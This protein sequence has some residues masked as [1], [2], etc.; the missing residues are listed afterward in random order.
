[1]PNTQIVAAFEPLSIN[2]IMARMRSTAFGFKQLGS[3]VQD[4]ILQFR[5]SVAFA[6][7]REV[8][9]ESF[10]D[11]GTPRSQDAPRRSKRRPCPSFTAEPS[12]EKAKLSQRAHVPLI[13]HLLDEHL[14]MNVLL[15]Q[16]HYVQ[17]IHY[18]LEAKSQVS[19]GIVLCTS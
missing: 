8:G 2:D 15:R 5:I 7:I 19:I 9:I 14:N 6:N 11:Y 17:C 12:K 18:L 13:W 10:L 4:L 3:R 1:M 16:V